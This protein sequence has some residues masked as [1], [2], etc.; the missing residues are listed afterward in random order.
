MILLSHSLSNH[1]TGQLCCFDLFS[2]VLV[3]SLS[4]SQ[5][6]LAQVRCVAQEVKVTVM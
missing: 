4:M 5:S 2:L 6:H 1:Q 3:K